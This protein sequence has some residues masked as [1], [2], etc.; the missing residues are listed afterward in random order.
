MED[1]QSPSILPLAER[2]ELAVAYKIQNPLASIRKVAHTFDVPP[3]SLGHRIKGRRDAKTF[4]QGRQRLTVLEEASLV[5]CMTQLM[6]WGWPPTISQLERMATH[7]LIRK[8]DRE[9]LGQHWYEAFLAR[10]PDF[11]LKYSKALDQARKDIS[12][13]ESYRKWFDLYTRTIKEYGILP[14]DQYNMG[15]KGMAMG[16]VDSGKIIVSKNEMSRYMAQP[17]HREWASLIECIS[18]DGFVV[19]AYIIFAGKRI[20]EEWAKSFPDPQA[21][22][23]VGDKGWTDEEIDAHWIRDTFDLYTKLRTT[24]SHRL[25][26]LDSQ[27]SHVSPEFVEYAEQHNIV[28]LCFPSRSAHHLQPLDVGLFPPL[29][30]AY[31]RRLR[32]TSIYGAVNVTKVQFLEILYGARLEAFTP[33]NI[34]GAW[35]SA[36]LIPYDPT[37]VI[38]KARPISASASLTDAHSNMVSVTAAAATRIDSLVAEIRRGEQSSCMGDGLFLREE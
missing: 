10:H 32:E 12:D 28:P 2:M 1:T 23:R 14:G 37:V 26:I 8:G 16:M 3:S 38:S 5:K 17:G 7:L 20:M 34:A 25:L 4:H 24:G 11:R 19:P 27:G 18:D 31:K 36:G 21:T 22:F 9:P 33:A 13:S 6:N 35:R 15:E 30:N 29:A